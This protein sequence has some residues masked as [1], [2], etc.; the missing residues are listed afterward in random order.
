MAPITAASANLA[1]DKAV[2]RLKRACRELERNIP[3]PDNLEADDTL[4][5]TLRPR[6]RAD[7]AASCPLS[8]PELEILEEGARAGHVCT[9]GEN[10]NVGDDATSEA[11]SQGGRS[12][13]GQTSRR[14][15]VKQPKIGVIR[16]YVDKLD[17]CLDTY[18]DAVS[19][20]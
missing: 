19:I 7:S 17:A 5:P 12:D 18:T 9:H 1:Y 15:R 20:L 11:G 13:R 3:P 16:E 2:T 8:V 14:A 10:R 6:E 4:A